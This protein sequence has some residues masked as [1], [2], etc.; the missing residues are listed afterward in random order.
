MNTRQHRDFSPPRA[1]TR[2]RDAGEHATW[3]E[4]VAVKLAAALHA[5]AAG[6]PFDWQVWPPV[7]EQAIVDRAAAEFG[8][9]PWTVH[10]PRGHAAERHAAHDELARRIAEAPWRHPISQVAQRVAEQAVRTGG[11]ALP[12]ESRHVVACAPDVYE[13]VRAQVEASALAGLYR[14]VEQP[15]L[16]DRQ[17]FVIDPAAAAAPEWKPEFDFP[18]R[19]RCASCLRPWYLPGYCGLC[20]EIRRAFPPTPNNLL[21]IITPY[22]GRVGG[23]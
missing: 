12:E 5:T 6:E 1:A 7:G 13:H 18:P 2:Q 10:G 19:Y 20:K 21:G 14:V 9:D 17:V 3:V 15:L 23:T 16:E 22:V 4:S 11:F 8:F